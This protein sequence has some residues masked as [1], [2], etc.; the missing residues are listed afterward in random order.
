MG[1]SLKT[2][3]RNNMERFR[4]IIVKQI[5][6]CSVDYEKSQRTIAITIALLNT[7]CVPGT[8]YRT[9]QE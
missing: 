6:K 2:P 8:A 1:L 4:R 7:Y 3:I 5:W 9:I